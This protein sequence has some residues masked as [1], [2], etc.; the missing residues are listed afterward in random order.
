MLVK[1]IRLKNGEDIICGIAN[2]RG[3]KIEVHEPM[4]VD[5]EH[6]GP[7][8]GQLI[9]T[10]WLPI[11]LVMENK[12]VLHSED[13]LTMMEPTEKFLE[14]YLN[15]LAKLNEILTAKEEVEGLSDNEI[16]EILN[17]MEDPDN[18]IIH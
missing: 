3:K 18:R 14:Y 4:T 15:T 17:A 2:K 13:V 12:I 8:A 1:I 9:M 6:R 16:T 11:N 10:N 7:H 5:V